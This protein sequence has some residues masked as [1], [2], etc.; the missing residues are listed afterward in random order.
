MQSLTRS[1]RIGG[2][3]G[4]RGWKRSSLFHNQWTKCPRPCFYF[5]APQCCVCLVLRAESKGPSETWRRSTGIQTLSTIRSI[6]VHRLPSF[7]KG[8]SGPSCWTQGHVQHQ[9]MLGKRHGGHK[10]TPPTFNTFR[11]WS[12]YSGFRKHSDLFTFCTL[13]VVNVILNG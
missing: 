1:R 13:C 12:T 3:L 4:G 8:P 10:V 2:R 6:S 9:C 5:K 7:H 11:E